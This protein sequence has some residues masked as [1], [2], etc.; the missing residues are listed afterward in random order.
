MSDMQLYSQIEKLP[1]NLKKEVEDF[2]KSLLEKEK[3]M[4]DKEILA[5][6]VFVGLLKVKSK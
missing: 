1:S 5:N 3:K 2:I 4:I 6:K